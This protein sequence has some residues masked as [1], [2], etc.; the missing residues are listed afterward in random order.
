[1]DKLDLVNKIVKV[2]DS[3]EGIDNTPI[4]GFMYPN[5]VTRTELFFDHDNDVIYLGPVTKNL[6]VDMES[7]T[8]SF[9]AVSNSGVQDVDFS[10]RDNNIRAPYTKWNKEPKEDVM[11]TLESMNQTEF[12]QY[13][14]KFWVTGKSKLEDGGENLFSLYQVL[15]KQRHDILT[16]YFKLKE[17]MTDSSI[18]SG[19]LSF[20]EK[21]LDYESVNSKSGR[22]LKMLQD[23]NFTY[24]DK[25][26]PVIHNARQYR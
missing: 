10:R 18:F 6:R 16:V 21:S 11:H 17:T 15:G 20:I 3:S 1:M 19:V 23:F 26:L 4:L 25:V 13:F 2:V 8:R 22:Y 9:I 24:K 14:K 7:G 5:F 12:W